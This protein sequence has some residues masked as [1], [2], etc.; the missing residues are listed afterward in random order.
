MM[1]LIKPTQSNRKP[2]SLMA[3]AWGSHWRLVLALLPWVVARWIIFAVA[4][5]PQ[6][7]SMQAVL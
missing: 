7:L 1:P 5:Q 6:S 2:L 4:G 3:L